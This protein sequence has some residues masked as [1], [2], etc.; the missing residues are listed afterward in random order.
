MRN[1]QPPG[2]LATADLP[3]STTVPAAPSIV[4]ELPGVTY[5][6][7]VIAVEPR[8][9]RA[10]RSPPRSIARRITERLILGVALLAL[11]AVWIW[12]PPETPRTTQVLR[13]TLEPEEIVRPES[14]AAI[15]A[16]ASKPTPPPWFSPQLLYVPAWMPAPLAT[17]RAQVP[18]HMARPAPQ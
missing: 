2:D 6:D 10:L 16:P 11:Y 15:K 1:S 8:V 13:G 7:S 5:S 18:L 9:S 3:G 4:P 12:I 17:P 14:T